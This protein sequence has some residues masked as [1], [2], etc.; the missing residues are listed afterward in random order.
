MK[1]IELSPKWLTP[2]IFIFKCPHCQKVWLSCKNVPMPMG[3]Q[4]AIFEKELGEKWNTLVTPMAEPTAWNFSGEDFSTLS[5]TP[6]INAEASG[7]WHGWIKNGEV[8][9]VN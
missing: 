3:A 9:G 6:S 1:L 5:V 4:F 2:N 7:H 8:S